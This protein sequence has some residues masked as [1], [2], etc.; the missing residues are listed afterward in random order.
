[1]NQNITQVC[2]SR[3]FSETY[4]TQQKRIEVYSTHIS[5]KYNYLN[6]L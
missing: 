3:I 2:A 6:Y 4:Q 5:Q 1:M